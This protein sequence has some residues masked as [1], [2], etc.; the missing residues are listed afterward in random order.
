MFLIVAKYLIPK[1]YRGMAVFPFVLM[2]Y[3]LDKKN[4]VFVN[5]EKIH[6]RQQLE[7]LIIPFFVFYF[8]EYVVR[9][10]QYKNA[11]LAYRNISFEREAYA[12]E[13]NLNYL[14]NRSFFQ[15]LKYITLK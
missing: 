14:K 4:E 8:L 7:L 13:T 1:G 9:L 15:F 11:A 12:N 10:I 2:K 3:D 6:L 5:H